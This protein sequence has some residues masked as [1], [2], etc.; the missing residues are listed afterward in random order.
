MTYSTASTSHYIG[1]KMSIHA[2]IGLSTNNPILDMKEIC[3]YWKNL[4]QDVIDEV[5]VMNLRVQ[6]LYAK[7]STGILRSFYNS[8]FHKE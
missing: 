8:P 7:V 1:C 5:V 2:A 3:R 4:G 6:A